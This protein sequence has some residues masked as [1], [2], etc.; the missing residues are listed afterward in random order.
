MAIKFGGEFVVSRKR[1]EVYDFL[2][3]PKRFA[4]L[5]PEYQGMTQEDPTHFTVKVKVG[6]SYIRG[7]ADVK[8]NLAEAV[9]PEHAIYKGL[10]NVAG[11]SSTM[12]AGF[13][14]EEVPE[15]TKV[16][17]SG[18]AQVFGKLAS[19]AGGLLEPLAKKNVEQLIHGLRT[20]LTP[21]QQVP[22]PE[23]PVPASGA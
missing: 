16:T 9:R 3:D 4:P 17:W 22:A 6:I 8:M 14:L 7:I 23:A 10:G 19:V 21:G 5:L 2:T 18:E 13:R 1:E 20:A 12:T 11:G 15:G